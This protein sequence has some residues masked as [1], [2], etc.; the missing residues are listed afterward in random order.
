M[1]RNLDS[2][3]RQYINRKNSF[4]ESDLIHTIILKKSNSLYRRKLSYKL[5]VLNIDRRN[6]AVGD[7]ASLK[8]LN[9][10]MINY[11]QVGEILIDR[12]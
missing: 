7:R 6:K 3:L 9:Y 10:N 12:Y 2:E 8:F 11:W 5:S 1:G 4:I